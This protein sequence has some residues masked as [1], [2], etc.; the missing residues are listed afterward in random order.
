MPTATEA[1]VIAAASLDAATQSVLQTRAQIQADFAQA[2]TDNT[3][4]VSDA[5]TRLKSWYVDPVNGNDANDGST[6][7]KAKKTLHNVISLA[8]PSTD[9]Y[10]FLMNDLVHENYS[11]L[12]ANMTVRGTGTAPDPTGIFQYAPATRKIAFKPTANESPLGVSTTV[13][14]FI[15]ITHNINFAG[16]DFVLADQ[17]A[18]QNI[19]AHLS[20]YNG[21][22]I[23]HGG[24]V[25]G[26]TPGAPG[27]LIGKGD[28]SPVGYYLYGSIAAAAK[29]RIF[30]G[31]AANADPRVSG[32]YRTNITSA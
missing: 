17:P 28:A 30:P 12:F 32:D 18:G 21:S 3:K 5:I 2:K 29:G 9:H 20:I 14:A 19:S 22:T 16:I 7:A 4:I 26:V 6:L 15:Q 31:V 23:S 11:Q 1:L 8:Q 25:L 27:T 24:N 13:T 10:V